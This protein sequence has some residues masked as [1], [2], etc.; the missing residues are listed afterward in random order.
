MADKVAEIVQSGHLQ[1]VKE[2][3][4]DEKAATL[5]IFNRSK[6]L[7][8]NYSSGGALFSKKFYLSELASQGNEAVSPCS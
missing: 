7:G 6:Y 8:Q 2:V 3:C 5:S 1:K 4:N